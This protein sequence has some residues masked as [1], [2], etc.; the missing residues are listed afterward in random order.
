[1]EYEMWLELGE[2]LGFKETELQQFVRAKEQ[3]YL[4][5]EERA[6]KRDQEKEYREEEI[7][8]RDLEE[9]E[10]SRQFELEKLRMQT[11]IE[12]ARLKME[13]ERSEMSRSN[14]EEA[15]SRSLRPKLPKF[16]EQK[17]DMDAF[18]ERFEK[19]AIAQKWNTD[20]WAVSLSP[21]L[22]GKGLQVYSSMPSTQIDD[23]DEL[24]K[25]LLRRYDLTE[26]GFR[27]KFRESKP[28]KGETAFQFVARSTR[29]LMRWVQMSEIEHSFEGLTDLLIRE[30]FIQT[31][32]SEM[33]LF[34]KERAPKDVKELTRLAEQYMEAHGGN[35]SKPNKVVGYNSNKANHS[36]RH[37]PQ[38][39]P[40]VSDKTTDD[41]GQ[42]TRRCF[43][44]GGEGHIARDHVEGGKIGSRPHKGSQSKDT[45]KAA[46]CKAS[47]KKKEVTEDCIRDEIS[48]KKESRIAIM[49]R[50]RLEDSGM[51]VQLGYVGDHPVQVLR[52]T[53]C[54][55]A[56]VREA[57]VNPDQITDKELPCILIDGTERM[58]RMAKIDVDTPFYVGK[59]EAMCMKDPIYD[60][61]I[62]NVDTAK[63]TADVDWRP[64]SEENKSAAV[65]TRAE[66][67]REKQPIKPLNVQ[68]KEVDFVGLDGLQKAQQEDKS[69]NRWHEIAKTKEGNQ[70][71]K[72]RMEIKN[73]ILY[74]IYRQK[75]G[76]LV[77]DV[78]Q[79]AVPETYREK[80][81]SLAHESIV[82]GHLGIQKTID[83]ISTSFYWPGMTSDVTRYCR[84]CDIC[85]RT[86]PKGRVTKVPLG[87]MP[88]IEEPFKRVAVDLIGPIYPS[89]GSKNRYIL[90]VVDYATRYPEAI[91]LPKIETERIA[92]AL[93]E[94][95]CRVGFPKEILSDR[96]SQFTSGLMEEVCRLVSVKQ[97][98]TTPYNPKCNGWCE[99]M[100]GVLKSMLK[101]MCQ[102]RPQDW[103]RYIPAVLFAYREVPQASTGFSPFELLYGRTVRGPMQALKEIWTDEADEKSET[104]NTYQYVLNLRD[105]LEETCKI[106]RESLLKSQGIYKHHYDKRTKNRQFEVG[107]KVLVLLPTDNNKLLLQ[108]KGPFDVVEVVNHMDYKVDVGGK[109]KIYHVNLLKLY[110]ERIDVKTKC[111][112]TCPIGSA[113]ETV[114]GIAVIEA[115]DEK[116]CGAV[117]DEN[118]LEL[119]NLSGKE[120]FKDVEISDE[121][122]ED[123]QSEVKALLEEFQDIF[124]DVP[125]TTHLQTHRIET[126][127]N[128][129]I[130][131]KP[132][133]I[134]YAK[135]KEVQEEVKKMVDLG[136]VEPSKSAYNAPIVMVKKKDQT[137]RVCIDFRKL[138]AVTHF[139]PEPMGDIDN[140][141]TKLHE[142]KYFS[143][144]DLS[145][146]YWQIPVEEKRQKVVTSFGSFHLV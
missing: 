94:I 136:I 12:M 82:G 38:Q 124:T 8:K 24:K 88:L 67:K 23:Y 80:V 33:S 135:R 138:N 52:D 41:K 108:W 35:I 100:N 34:L 13:Q 4:D 105:R 104:R 92:E 143:K 96:G 79:I 85:Q 48:S 47:R 36:P 74:R 16:D 99:R 45:N 39:N 56:A 121:L 66:A 95:F 62:G 2:R 146:G 68:A 5:R 57:L 29:Y 19:F 129:P 64:L 77:E 122:S 134:P 40:K 118:L 61:V 71:D 51:P 37:N 50:I 18:L 60:L 106:A 90:T 133:P 103:D 89:S 65:M 15:R 137:N 126:T 9:A 116:D 10:K 142:D 46:L 22:T 28:E 63:L 98:F 81:M 102:E 70:G 86:T 97:L 115:E 76:K 6:R 87:E 32:S 112:A 119:G 27:L 3:E 17:D 128:N 113:K 114:A 75:R 20:N 43:I 30:Q 93:M 110:V 117:D 11:D 111:K 14:S 144:F 58:F 21:L 83:R 7:R 139:D 72:Y 145:K 84:S 42:R 109:I 59:L 125:G 49:G 55:S 123:Q 31:C 140:I 78:R 44:C 127:S 131:V 25:A 101:K 73:N 69:L 26:E 54:S 120:T 141:M 130:R 53:G 107:Q 132:Y 1:M 91:A